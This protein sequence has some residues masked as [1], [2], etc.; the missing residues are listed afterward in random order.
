MQYK[1]TLY[2][3]WIYF[4]STISRFHFECTIIF[5][6]SLF[7]EFNKSIRYLFRANLLW[8]QYFI[9]DFTLH[10]LSLS[11]IQD[12]YTILF[13]NSLWMHY[14]FRDFTLNSLSFSRFHF[15][16]TIFFASSLWMHYLFRD[17][18]WIHYLSREFTINALS[19]SQIQY[20]YSIYFLNSI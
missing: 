8:I 13:A 9:R 3:S 7:R 19:S 15:E 14:V 11:R 10:S 20:K 12:K 6:K 18:I 1:Y 16:F 4:E 17:F 5:A 2:I